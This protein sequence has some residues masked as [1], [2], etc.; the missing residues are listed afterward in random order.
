MLHALLLSSLRCSELQL[1]GSVSICRGVPG[2]SA[3]CIVH[4]LP[5]NVGA[6]AL[7]RGDSKLDVATAVEGNCTGGWQMGPPSNK[8]LE[9][10]VC[11]PKSFG[12][13]TVDPAFNLSH[14]QFAGSFLSGMVLQR[15]P[16]QSALFGTAPPGSTVTV[17]ATGPDGWSF[18]GSGM[19]STLVDVELYG[20]W[21]ILL[22]PR[23]AGSGYSIA[24]T[25]S[26]GSEQTLVNVS[27]GDIWFCT[28]Q[29]RQ[30]YQPRHVSPC[31]YA[32]AG[33]TQWND[34]VNL[35][36]CVPRAVQSN[37]ED[38]V[39]QTFSRNNSYSAADTGKFNHIKLFQTRWRPRKN[40]T[41]ILPADGSSTAIAWETVRTT[42]A[43][44]PPKIF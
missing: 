6:A 35:Q 1:D 9:P 39:S 26:D 12:C 8:T 33:G 37:M 24:A 22:P 4:A 34:S 23:P 18:S 21:K 11:D 43:A 3:G 10:C 2:D 29:V 31:N 42:L 25:C 15:G 30:S 13:P 40:E 36:T 28:G 7:G 44:P 41:W 38:P 27:F 5:A 14:V 20:T 17:H 19:A 32:S 16:G